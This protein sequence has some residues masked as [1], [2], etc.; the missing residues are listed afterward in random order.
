VQRSGHRG[1]VA[2]RARIKE[3][4]GGSAV[5]V[6]LTATAA[7]DN[8]RRRRRAGSRRGAGAGLRRRR[9]LEMLCG[10]PKYGGRN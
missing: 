7:P 6:A 8:C 5:N 1:G 4:S 3:S 10:P 2:V 9:S